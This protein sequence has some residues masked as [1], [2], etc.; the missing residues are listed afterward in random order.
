[1]SRIVLTTIG[2]FGDLHPKI[3]LALELRY[4]GHEVVLATHQEY[5][6]KIEALGLNFHH[7]RPD[8]TALND[9]QEMAKMMDLK[10][11]TEYVIKNWIGAN[12]RETYTDLMDIAKDADFIVAGE[13]VVA[14]RLVAEKLD[15][16]WAFVVLQPASFLSI[17]DPSVLP[18][19][20][21]LAKFRG[22][23]SLANRGI[24]QL[25]R[26]MSRSWAEPIHQFRRELDLVPLKGNPFID[27][28]YSPY[29][30]LAMFSSVFA[31][32]QPDWP[33]NTLI[34]GFSFYDGSKNGVQLPSDLE[35]FLEADEPPVVFTLG[36]AAVM[37][38]GQFYKE[39]LS[40]A[41]LLN[42]RAVLLIGKNDPPKNLSDDIIAVSYVPYSQI[43]PYA[44]AI[45]HQGGIG[46]TAQA[47][48]AG[49]PTLVM[50]YSHDQP[51]NAARVERLGTSRT[52]TRKQYQAARVAQQLRQLLDNSSYSAKAAEIGQIIQAENGVSLACDAIEK[53]LQSV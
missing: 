1:M 11:G 21:F 40:A 3:A 24:L 19:L 53:Q 32:P 12:L 37:T 10:T 31:K 33:A 17:Y 44:C 15:I 47:L 25:S 35:Q 34:T 2:S 48:R 4:R 38:P 50:P 22:L 5:Q 52:I 28:K 13:G 41:K 27:D 9:P 20:P 42:R 23:G 43:F 14:G 46:T 18:I 49:R 51:D 45:V 16:P 36:S 30:V 7:I 29:L 6:N 39:S 8:N 26:V